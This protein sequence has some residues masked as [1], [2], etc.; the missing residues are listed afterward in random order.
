MKRLTVIL[1]LFVLLVS[2]RPALAAELPAPVGA[3]PT[4]FDLHFLMDDG[5]HMHEHIGIDTDANGDGYVCMMHVG[6]DDA[7]HLHVDNNLP[8]L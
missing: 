6:L 7:L 5:Q 2:V 1:V 8:L 4:G 3:C